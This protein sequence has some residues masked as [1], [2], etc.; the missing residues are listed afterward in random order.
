MKNT[1]EER[2]SCFIEHV[3]DYVFTK[4]H[5]HKFNDG[6]WLSVIAI[7]NYVFT[8]RRIG[9][10]FYLEDGMICY[11]IIGDPKV[12]SSRLDDGFYW[13]KKFYRR[14]NRFRDILE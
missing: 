10:S 2:M 3:I 11:A 1:P 6:G 9:Y 7:L 4:N 13:F 12:D 14:K 8:V 5:R